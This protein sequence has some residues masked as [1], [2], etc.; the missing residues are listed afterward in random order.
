[1]GQIIRILHLE[2]DSNDAELAQDALSAEGIA[3]E[4]VVAGNREEFAVALELGGFDLVIADYSLPDFDGL[5]ALSMVRERCP[6][7]P[8]MFLSGTMGEEIAIESLRNGATDYILKHRISR[9]APAVRRA[10]KEREER[11]ARNQAEKAL[12]ESE[13]RY[14]SLFDNSIDAILLTF[15]DGRILAANH[16]ARRIF[17][18]SEEE[19]CRIGS[20]GL[21]DTAD[22]R[23]QAALDERT[24][25][26]K[27]KGELSFLREDG[28]TFPCEISSGLFKDPDGNEMTS[29]IIRD[30]TER[31]SLERQVLHAQKM[32]AIGT[33]A[34]GVAHD[35]NNL[36][37]A[38]IGFGTL[39]EMRMSPDDPLRINVSNILSAADRAA[40]LT[41]SLLTFS[42][43]QPLDT[44]VVD[45]N[46]VIRNVEKLLIQVI[47]EDIECRI[48]L[49]EEDLTILADSGQID[50]VLLNLATNA[51]DAMPDGGELTISTMRMD[52]DQ[53]FINA[54]G[55]GAIAHYAVLSV[56]DTGLGMDEAT[57]QRIFEPFFTTKELGKGTGLGLSIIFGIVKQH[58]GFISCYA[59]QGIGTTFNIYFPLHQGKTGQ[60]IMQDTIQPAGG[61]ETILLAEDEEMV[62]SLTRIILEG[63][64]YRV[65]EAVNGSNAVQQ[66][67]DHRNEVELLLLDLIMPKKNGRDAYNAIREVNPLIRVIFTSGYPADVANPQELSAYGFDFI[68]KPVRPAELLNKV[69]EVLDRR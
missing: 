2:D 69:R 62:R 65:I 24:R 5:T 61:T 10:L 28:S 20:D 37:T 67:M 25:T 47:R 22:P 11:V 34:G 4:T 16:E 40:S 51:R 41:K 23:L 27:F 13:A 18:R 49:A 53:Q 33:L 43:E 52:M 29:M 68:A 31:K 56:T 55:Y 9:L 59:E 21:V 57:R 12:R 39:L 36:L 63:A 44:K 42:R 45:L 3:C 50:Q 1:M 14:R 6:D 48:L 8:F 17:G 60:E 19:I 66:Y 26:G 7:C 64:G 58:D 35:F 38:I 30:I 32:D 15:P 46:Y 54:H